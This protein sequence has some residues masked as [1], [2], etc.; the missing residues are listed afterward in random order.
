MMQKTKDSRGSFFRMI[1]LS[2]DPHINNFSMFST[3]VIMLMGIM[4]VMYKELCICIYKN[5][6]YV[7]EL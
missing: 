4:Y 5:C 6:I 1:F 3:L 7:E 2:T